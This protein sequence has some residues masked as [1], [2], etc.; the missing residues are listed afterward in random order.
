MPDAQGIRQRQ[1]VQRC[2]LLI[3]PKNAVELVV[4]L[5][6]PAHAVQNADL[7]RP[8]E[9]TDYP[10]FSSINLLQDRMVAA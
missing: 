1:P 2:P 8:Q 3:F 5:D 9:L 7:A 10:S 6:F 4:G